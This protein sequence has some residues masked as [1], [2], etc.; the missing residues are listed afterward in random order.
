MFSPPQGF[1]CDFSI[2]TTMSQD[3]EA[4]E[5]ILET[6]TG[7]SSYQL[8]TVQR[9]IKMALIYDNTSSMVESQKIGGIYPIRINNK[10]RLLHAKMALIKFT[11]K[12]DYIYRL[13][14]FTG[15]FTMASLNHQ[16]EMLWSHDYKKTDQYINDIIEAS[17]FISDL[18]KN[19][20]SK[21]KLIQAKTGKLISEIQ[22]IPK[23]NTPSRFFHS[24][25][26][27]MLESS[28]QQFERYKKGNRGKHNYLTLGSPFFQ[29]DL[30]PENFVIIEI[31]N[32]LKAKGIL[33]K[34]HEDTFLQTT[35]AN[36]TKSLGEACKKENIKI[37]GTDGTA[38]S[39]HSKYIHI[40]RYENKWLYNNVFYIGSGNLTVN[41]F[42]EPRNIECGV[43]FE[44][45]EGFKEGDYEDTFYFSEEIEE[46]SLKELSTGVK[47]EIK[48]DHLVVSVIS[49]QIKGSTLI[50]NLEEEKEFIPFRVISQRDEI[51]K[52][53]IYPGETCS[54]DISPETTIFDTITIL[55]EN[56][57]RY[58]VMVFGTDGL[59][60]K[61]SLERKE[62]DEVFDLLKTYPNF[63]PINEEDEFD[64]RDLEL[65]TPY[66]NEEEVIN[67]RKSFALFNFTELIEHISR[68]N[69]K[70]ENDNLS[71]WVNTLK[72]TLIDCLKQEDKSRMAKLGVEKL[73]ILKEDGFCPSLKDEELL[74]YVD[75][76][77]EVINDWENA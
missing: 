69:E 64:Q 12:K 51:C 19:H 67:H 32:S 74:L 54:F 21:H 55:D 6:L 60:K 28:I 34:S 8:K 9:E 49:A 70:I 42:K 13:I 41:G 71:E 47:E 27:S 57:S 38:R 1:K 35:S 37:F 26:H 33:T 63:D 22:S 68:E 25:E 5:I 7:K 20:C 4:L 31:L 14:V 44:H 40:A 2:A 59:P 48:D 56:G 30:K 24:I 52:I 29:E 16:I 77:N 17:Q 61:V 62:F 18:L 65:T 15:N 46:E 76:I 75:S 11:N 50:L 53:S 36:Y 45:Q 66:A 39:L 23:G 72:F 10:E 58:P 43:I 73:A 3:T